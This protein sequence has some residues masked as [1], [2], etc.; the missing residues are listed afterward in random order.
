VSLGKADDGGDASLRA[1]G[2][3]NIESTRE[4][5]AFQRERV[6]RPRQKVRLGR[7]ESGADPSYF[8]GAGTPPF[9]A[10]RSP[11]LPS[12]LFDVAPDNV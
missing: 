9:R 8:S 4:Q 10:G 3:A 2:E 7:A 11:V 1:I 12:L 6:G 5:S